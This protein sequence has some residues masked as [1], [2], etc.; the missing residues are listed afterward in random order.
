MTRA[1]PWKP[2]A[3]PAWAGQLRHACHPLRVAG[4]KKQVQD[5]KGTLLAGRSLSGFRA[6]ARKP[7]VNTAKTTGPTLPLASAINGD[8][9]TQKENAYQRMDYQHVGSPHPVDASQ[10]ARRVLSRVKQRIQHQAFCR[11]HIRHRQ[12]EDGQPAFA[13]P[14]LQFA[15]QKRPRA[16]Q[17]QV[18]QQH[19]WVQIRRRSADIFSRQRCEKE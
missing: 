14:N 10:A 1:A 6:L 3:V 16:I 4:V 5:P 15:N 7:A 11:N 18:R 19:E 9:N 2:L 13:P 17:Q 12:N 8:A